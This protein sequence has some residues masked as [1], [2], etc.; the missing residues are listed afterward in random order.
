M[1]PH[2]VSELREKRARLEELRRRQAA[3]VAEHET[4]FGGGGDAPAPAAAS[5]TGA[6]VGKLGELEKLFAEAL[7]QQ[8]T[9]VGSVDSMRK[10]IQTGRFTPDHYIEMWRTRLGLNAAAAAAA[11]APA[12][13]PARASRQRPRTPPSV[14]SLRQEREREE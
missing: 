2:R 11:P 14:S 4:R 6:P 13:A 5:P 10:H 9:T 1:D 3:A 8:V 7:R 12:P